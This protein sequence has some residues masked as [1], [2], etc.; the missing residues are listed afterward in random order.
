MFGYILANQKALSDSD[1]KKYRS[2][3]CGQCKQ[4]KKDYGHT[5]QLVLNYDLTFLKLLLA[6]LYDE[7]LEEKNERCE[8]HPIIPHQFIHTK[9]DEYTADMTILLSYYSL[10]DHQKDGD[11]GK[12]TKLFKELER[13][14]PLLQSKYPRQAKAITENLDKIEEAEKDDCLEPEKLASFFGSL[15]GE[16]FTPYDDNW[17][18]ELHAIGDGVGRFIYLLDAYLDLKKDL[19]KGAF[20][21][22]SKMKDE[23]NFREK[24]ID[25]LSWAA[26]DAAKAF[27]Y[28]P[29]DEHNTLLQNILYSGIWSLIENGKDKQ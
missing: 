7:E 9:S 10:L 24:V 28:L 20:N 19:K 16:V 5:G 6:D 17:K 22:F 12:H 15:L 21:P 18:T 11:K 1:K 25:L 29:L 3:Y 23:P 4:L 26:S 14:I 13:Y 8:I 27:E 2:F